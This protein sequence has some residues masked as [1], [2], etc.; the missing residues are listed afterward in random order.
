[1]AYVGASSGTGVGTAASVSAPAGASAGDRILVQMMVNV[2][3]TV[4][5]PSG[6]TLLR[7]DTDS[8]GGQTLYTFQKNAA[9]VA[10]APWSFPFNGGTWEH[11][12]I[13]TAWSGRTQ[14][15]WVV[16]FK[17]GASVASGAT[18]TPT[19]NVTA[20]AGDDIAI[21]VMMADE[22]VGSNTSFA[23]WTNSATERADVHRDWANIA[24]ATKENL[25]AGAMGTF[26]VTPTYTTG[27]VKMQAHLVRLPVPGD[28]EYIAISAVANSA[29]N[30]TPTYPSLTADDGLLLVVGQKPSTANGGTVTTPAGFTLLASKLAAGGYGAT[31]G[32][33][34]GNT[35]LYLYKKDTVTGSESGTLTITTGTN[36]VAW[37]FFI[38][39][40]SNNG[41]YDFATSDAEDTSAGNVSLTFGA[42][43]VAAADVLIGLMCSPTDI[44]SGA[45]AE[46]FTGTGLTTGTVSEIAD[47][48]IATGNDIGGLAAVATVT[49]ASGSTAVTMTATIGG[50]ST[51]LRGPG[52][53]VRVR[54]GTS[55]FTGTGAA[56]ASPF[57]GSGSGTETYSGTGSAALPPVAVAGAGAETFT[58]TAAAAVSPFSA[59]GSGLVSAIWGTASA[60]VSPFG[61]AGA[62]A[63][64]FAGS[65]A[66]AEAPFAGS[67]AGAETFSGSGSGAESPFA[68]AA[69]GTELY[70][71]TAS[72][73]EA[74][75][76]A[77]GAGAET[78]SGSGSAAEQPFAGA[79]SGAQTF[80]GTASAATQPFGAA[81]AALETFTAAAVA[82]VQAFAAAA[83]GVSGSGISGTASAAASPFASSAT[84]A[85]TFTATASAALAP[86][87]ASAAALETFTATVAAALQ[88][89]AASGAGTTGGIIGAGS[90]AVSPF[91]AA[92]SGAE[93]FTGALVAALQAF[94]A[95]SSG[96]ETFTGTGSAAEQPFAATA[97]GSAVNGITGTGAA[98]LASFAALAAAVQTFSGSGSA[99]ARSPAAA[100]AGTETITGSGSAAIPPAGAAGSGLETY[101]AQV[102]A[103]LAPFAVTASGVSGSTFIT[104]TATVIV[105][106]FAAA[107]ALWILPDTIAH[108]RRHAGA[109]FPRGHAAAR[110]PGGHASI[111]VVKPDPQ[112][113]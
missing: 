33:D 45:S 4:A 90:A 13:A 101:V 99:A 34:T 49:A 76:G 9:E 57:G 37:A 95:A 66:A 1:M 88:A 64:T 23:S 20:V 82:A 10:S 84:G 91:A 47:F 78:Y 61:A 26:S 93:T 25:S 68:A 39:V 52:L 98:A 72:A 96:G 58:S 42:V 2:D 69:I 113:T 18:G 19:N 71:A 55:G 73:A 109:V 110:F 35:N 27:T 107:G 75:F 67:G 6:F 31:L 79:S 87:G 48:K 5:A 100:G 3:N 70:T 56:A 77:A 85:E 40:R 11:A 59:S 30:P 44:A 17:A 111:I 80:T 43:D 83:T 62:G 97:T 63:E 106:S 38:Q 54:K 46:A 112:A 60:A 36:N 15:A 86:F 104:G 89:F 16:D 50:T 108:L 74:P 92:G 7:Q 8:V 22:N 21:A 12:W 65:G 41:T 53:L 102:A 14:G 24:V 29:T 32:A 28:I 103:A 105:K 81:A 94:A 51:N